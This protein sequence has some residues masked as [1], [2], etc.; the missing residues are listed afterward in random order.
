LQPIRR[1]TFAS[2]DGVIVVLDTGDELK[3]LATNTLDG[4]VLATPALVGGNIY[5]RTDRH[6]YAFGESSSRP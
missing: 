2:A 6:L 5:V 4:G 3:I 1:S